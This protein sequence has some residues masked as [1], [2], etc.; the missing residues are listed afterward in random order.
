MRMCFDSKNHRCVNHAFKFFTQRITGVY[1]TILLPAKI[2]DWKMSRGNSD[3]WT[4]CVA[5]L[6][7]F[8]PKSSFDIGKAEDTVIRFLLAEVGIVTLFGQFVG[9]ECDQQ[10][11]Q[12][13]VT[14]S[15]AVLLPG[16]GQRDLA[17][18]SFNMAHEVLALDSF[19]NCWLRQGLSQKAWGI[20]LRQR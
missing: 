13:Q 1:A 17:G 15:T 20:V 10:A 2:L 5:V 19:Y 11:L 4:R 3:F 12:L 9:E 8:P 18:S 16:S 6:S 14:A 7:D